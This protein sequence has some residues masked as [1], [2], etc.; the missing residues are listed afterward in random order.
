MKAVARLVFSYFTCTPMLRASSAV[1][2]VTI[3]VSAYVLGHQHQG[4]AMLWLAFFGPL[5]FYIGSALM[6][7]M[8]GRMARS[9]LI[10][11]L[12]YGRIKLLVS[13]YTTILIVSL[14]MAALMY[15]GYSSATAPE[16][17]DPVKYEQWRQYV[18]QAVWL[19]FL[20]S[21]VM[22]GWLYLAMWFITS[23]R[24]I[25]GYVKGLL[26][27][28]FI[29]YAPTRTLHD[30]SATIGGSVAQVVV[31]WL[32][33]GTG[34]LLWPRWKAYSAKW[35]LLPAGGLGA[36]LK[37]QVAGR[38]ID[39]L[40]GTS[41]PWLLIAAQVAPIVFTSTIGFYSAAVW[42]FYLTIFSTVAGGIAGQAAE[43]SRT[44]WLRGNWSRDELFSQVERSFWRHNGY[45]LG[46]LILLM[47]AI[48]SYAGLSVMLLAA[49]LP[50]LALGTV[51]S[52]YLGL[53][54]TRGLH[55]LEASLAI[56]VMLALMAVAVIAARSEGETRDLATVIVLEALLAVLAWVLRGAAK[57]RWAAIDWM[58]CRPD[59]GL[60]TR[61]AS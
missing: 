56:T 48:G 5:A 19:V 54:I 49:G 3:L 23:Q 4:E 42:L 18:N 6:P 14:P 7:L 20:G 27:I 50:L 55:A 22:A 59:R 45:V 51:L 11:V 44:L 52:T 53:M 16:V 47:V 15:L 57:K 17:F 35:R 46:A 2:L 28:M 13:A 41:N 29:I 36:F 1:G 37:R 21:I 34:F 31:I 12:P 33:F 39:L 43:R 10:R 8:F 58:L 24:S 61:M 26:V 30:L 9:H 32:V 25:A 60:V 38:E 40:L